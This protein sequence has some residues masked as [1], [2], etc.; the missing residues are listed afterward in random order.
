MCPNLH[1]YS[2][3]LGTVFK[4]W[5]LSPS[6]I[7][8]LLKWTWPMVS[9]ITLL[10]VCGEGPQTTLH[11]PLFSGFLG[12]PESKV[13]DSI[14]IHSS[15]DLASHPFCRRACPSKCGN[16]THFTACLVRQ[17]ISFISRFLRA[18]SIYTSLFPLHLV[19]DKHSI[20]NLLPYG[21]KHVRNWQILV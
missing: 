3:A 7:K 13:I 1:G 12:W 2:F 17:S 11:G 16:Y 18:T 8:N 15:E 6:L 14:Y 20:F 19:S 9:L 21:E 4:T 5:C 10:C